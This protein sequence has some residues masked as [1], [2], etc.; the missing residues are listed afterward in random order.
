M[1]ELGL[2]TLIAYLMGSVV[3]AL[4]IGQFRG[5]DIRT[6]GSGNP[7]GTNALRT[8]G[9]GFAAATVVI[10]IG[11]GLARGGL[12]AGARD[13]RRRAGSRDR[14]RL[15]RGLLCGGCRRRPRLAALARFSRRQ[16]RRDARCGT[17]MALAPMLLAIALTAWVA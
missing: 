11:K 2:K 9:L 4:L 14:A 10:D 17:L 15:A 12:A 6:M 7:G 16:G 3:G 5:V 1:L 8:Q 13:A